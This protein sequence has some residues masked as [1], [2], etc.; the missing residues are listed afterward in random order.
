MKWSTKTY[1]T[2]AHEAYDNQKH[3][4]QLTSF[5]TQEWT[6]CEQTSEKKEQRKN[7]T[8]QQDLGISLQN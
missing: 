2:S 3:N 5:C 1:T 6:L 7:H 8:K 4:I